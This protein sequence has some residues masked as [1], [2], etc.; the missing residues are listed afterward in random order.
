MACCCCCCY[1][2]R[3]HGAGFRHR[4]GCSRLWSVFRCD[5]YHRPVSSLIDACDACDACSQH[6][7]RWPFFS[8]F[9][10]FT[11]Y[12]VFFS[13]RQ[14]AGP[15]DT[16]L[17]CTAGNGH[18]SLELAKT[19]ALK[20]GLGSLYIMDIQASAFTSCDHRWALPAGVWV[21]I[22]ENWF[23]SNGSEVDSSTSS[24][25][26]RPSTHTGFGDFRA[27]PPCP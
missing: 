25:L 7:Q 9:L 17:D 22:G 14:V 26:G 11:F 15:G 23:V 12:S 2:A 18:D 5:G 19:I 3:E 4:S 16:V 1:S 10:S 27:S 13:R 8:V 20:D 21:A 24:G 6:P